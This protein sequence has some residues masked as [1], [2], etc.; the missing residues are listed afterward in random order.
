MVPESVS[1]E[2]NNNDN[3]VVD[4]ADGFVDV[5]RDDDDG[6]RL[7]NSVWWLPSHF[8]PKMTL[9]GRRCPKCNH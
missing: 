5:Q 6:F 9:S 7:P 4:D 8:P 1:G 3:S 2:D